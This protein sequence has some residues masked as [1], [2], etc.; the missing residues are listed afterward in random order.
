MPEQQPDL[1]RELALAFPRPGA[2]LPARSAGSLFEHPGL[3]PGLAIA[4]MAAGCMT[5]AFTWRAA[6]PL[7]RFAGSTFEQPGLGPGLILAAAAMPARY[8]GSF[9]EKESHARTTT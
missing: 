8:A 9:F 7:A 4:R 5:I 6:A 2:V 1:G 3:R